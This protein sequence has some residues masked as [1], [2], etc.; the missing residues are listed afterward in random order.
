MTY[1]NIIN[2]NVSQM[3]LHMHARTLDS[4][5]QTWSFLIKVQHIKSTEC[6]W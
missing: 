5:L 3:I 2:T 4:D 6:L 1:I